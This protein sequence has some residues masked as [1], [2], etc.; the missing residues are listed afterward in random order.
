[1]DFIFDQVVDRY[2]SN[3]A[4]WDGT[5]AAYGQDVIPLSVADMDFKGPQ[6]L[7]DKAKQAVEAGIFGYT[8]I[9]PT[10]YDTV[11]SW[12]KRQYDWSVPAEWVVFCPRI[13]QAAS[14]IIQDFTKPG[15]SIMIHTPA[16]QP[17]A[18]VVQL[19]DRK[20]VESPLIFSDG[21]YELDFADMEKKM[22]AGVKILLLVSPHNPTGRV[23]TA[24]ELE[25]IAA[26]CIKYDVLI[27]SDDIHADFIR[28]GHRHQVISQL[29]ENIAERCFICTSPGKTFNLASAEIANIVIPN[30]QLRKKFQNSLQKAGIHNPTLLAPPMLV[31][32]YTECDQWLIQL[33]AYVENNLQF[34]TDFIT[35]NFPK[36]KVVEPEGT[37][38][39]W[40]DCR[41]LCEDEASLKRWILEQSQVSVSFGSSFGE[42]GEG[43]IR[44]N[45][46]APQATLLTALQRM[47]RSYQ[48]IST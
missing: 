45:L 20:L 8:E 37:Y 16:Y 30:E 47:Q 42:I 5:A 28:A 40:V 32:A 36:L 14:L 3:S 34:V 4:K 21:R 35:Q 24:K 6:Q 7:I 17:L 41:N 19:H 22:Q 2:G 38:L 9:Y 44:I 15:D 25:G 43:F 18:K 33:K 23:W 39:L 46:A 31:A 13:I 26:L 1:M 29:S 10:Y 11:T 27:V 12:F 48:A